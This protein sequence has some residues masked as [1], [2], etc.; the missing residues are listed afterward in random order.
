MTTGTLKEKLQTGIPGHKWR[1]GHR[2]YKWRPGHRYL[3]ISFKDTFLIVRRSIVRN[4]KMTEEPTMATPEEAA[5]NECIQAEVAELVNRYVSG[6]R[7]ERI[8]VWTLALALIQKKK[9]TKKGKNY[10]KK[11]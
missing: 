9:K 7:S 10:K 2:K 1:P 4:C 6:S 3:R 8:Q 5:Q 11:N